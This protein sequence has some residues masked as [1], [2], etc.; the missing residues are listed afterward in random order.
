MEDVFNLIKDYWQKELEDSRSIF[1][2]DKFI[3]EEI[4]GKVRRGKLIKSVAIKIKQS[5]RK[6]GSYSYSQGELAKFYKV[7]RKSI[8]KALEKLEPILGI[9]FLL[10]ESKNLK[11]KTKARF[12][13]FMIPPSFIQ[14]IKSKKIEG[15]KR[16]D[17]GV[18]KEDDGVFKEDDGVFKGGMMGSF[19]LTSYNYL[20]TFPTKSNKLL[21]KK[22]KRSLLLASSE[23]EDA[24]KTFFNSLPMNSKNLVE[25]K[26]L[27]KKIK[28]KRFVLKRNFVTFS[29]YDIDPKSFLTHIDS[30]RWLLKS[31]ETLVEKNIL[32][33]KNE[34]VLEIIKTWNLSD[35]DRFAKH[36]ISLDSVES[37]TFKLIRLAITYR[38]FTHKITTDN[39][40]LAIDNFV[41][42]TK[43][44]PQLKYRKS[45]IKF[46]DNFLVVPSFY[47]DWFESCL[48]PKEKAFNKIYGIGSKYEKTLERVKKYL[49]KYFFKG[50]KKLANDEIYSNLTRLSIFSDNMVKDHLTLN[51]CDFT[52]NTY[53]SQYFEYAYKITGNKSDWVPNINYLISGDVK[54]Q[55]F[56]YIRNTPGYESFGEDKK[57]KNNA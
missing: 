8:R 20:Y 34:D 39:F 28:P 31:F 52:I 33:A 9:G 3:E 29:D 25:R 17:D 10:V 37:N 43:Q 6:I 40:K 26:I 12:R 19:R 13:R 30:H 23:K 49:I 55:F 51:L 42:I 45:N 56:R 46:L 32:P 54:G 5:I 44:H 15:F 18:F 53:I 47:Q 4:K 38:M 7:P 11:R 57:D 36:R 22:T 41:N 1:Y 35:T 24:N 21:F 2:K 16:L 27:M 50:S 14:D 48:L